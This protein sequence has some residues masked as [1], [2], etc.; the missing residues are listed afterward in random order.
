MYSLSRCNSGKGDTKIM[1]R[2]IIETPR[3]NMKKCR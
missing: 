2:G 3:G 1:I